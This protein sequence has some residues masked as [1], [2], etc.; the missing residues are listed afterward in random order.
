L[1]LSDPGRDAQRQQLAA[2]MKALDAQITARQQQIASAAANGGNPAASRSGQ[3]RS[4]PVQA[5]KP[6]AFI[7]ESDAESELQPDGSVLLTGPVP[8]KDTYTFEAELR[9]ANSAV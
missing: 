8:D 5:L 7:T 4:K 3:N 1:K 9:A 2:Q 6:T